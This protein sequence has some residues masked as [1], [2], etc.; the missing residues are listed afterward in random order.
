MGIIL[1][2]RGWA[3]FFS[4]QQVSM[5][6]FVDVVRAILS[7][8]SYVNFKKS[9]MLLTALQIL[10]WGY[11]IKLLF[12]WLLPKIG[13]LFF[14]IEKPL[15]WVIWIVIIVVVITSLC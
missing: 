12:G 5:R 15:G 6:C 11:L 4:F 1:Y 3:D 8:F 13:G 2:S 9:Y 7:Y 10:V 14:S